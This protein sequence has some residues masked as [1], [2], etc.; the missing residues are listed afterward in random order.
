M[1]EIGRAL[2]PIEIKMTA[3]PQKKMAVPFRLLEPVIEAGDLEL[4]EGAIINQY[5]ELMYLE[6]KVRSIPV[7][8][9]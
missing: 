2:Y 8:Y 9:L 4:G 5:P 1:L 3:K 6:E 7:G